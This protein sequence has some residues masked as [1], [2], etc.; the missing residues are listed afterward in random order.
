MGELDQKD[1]QA[2]IEVDR[3]FIYFG[4][5]KG[6]L[7]LGIQTKINDL[8]K[9][10]GLNVTIEAITEPYGFDKAYVFV[11][12]NHNE[13][14]NQW[15]YEDTVETLSRENL[16]PVPVIGFDE[17]E[18]HILDNNTKK[19][20]KYD[21]LK[22]FLPKTSISVTE[23]VRCGTWRPIE[24]INHDDVFIKDNE[25]H[26]LIYKEVIGKVIRGEP[27][28]LKAKIHHLPT[29]RS[30]TDVTFLVAA[31]GLQDPQ[32]GAYSTVPTVQ[33]SF[34][35][36]RYADRT[37]WLGVQHVIERVAWVWLLEFAQ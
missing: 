10:D 24:P 36:L 15:I 19:T 26:L 18:I 32:T 4:K 28:N 5:T 13:P 31:S 12:K 2:D 35:P 21:D 25:W 7:G 16:W 33:V 30:S 11:S 14:F 27:T 3:D 23:A 34:E 9:A 37:A 22:L 1:I 29:D 20:S 6:K 8:L 17:I